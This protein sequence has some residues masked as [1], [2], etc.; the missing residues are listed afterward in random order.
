MIISSNNLISKT[1]YVLDT[2]KTPDDSLTAIEKSIKRN[3][4]KKEKTL[5]K[6]EKAYDS[7]IENAE[8]IPGL[9]NFY[10]VKE[11]LE[12][13]VYL[14]LKPDQLEKEY[15]YSMTRVAGDNISKSFS[16]DSGAMIGNFLMV[17]RK[18]NDKV[19]I[20]KPVIDYRAEQGD[21]I[22]RSLKRAISESL[23]ESLKIEGVNKE[24]GNILVDATKFFMK[25][26]N[27]SGGDSLKKAL[28]LGGG[29][30]AISLDISNSYFDKIRSSNDMSCVEVVQHF[31]GGKGDSFHRVNCSLTPRPNTGYMP[32]YNNQRL[33]YFTTEYENMS[34]QTSR[35]PQK[36][37][38]NRFQ[39]EKADPNLPLS[40]PKQPITFWLDN[41][42]PAKYKDA[43]RK[44]LLVWNKVFE[45]VGIKN[46]IVVNDVPENEEGEMADANRNMVYSIVNTNLGAYAVGPSFADPITGQ[47]YSAKIRVNIPEFVR[48]YDS[49]AEKKMKPIS[50]KAL[51]AFGNEIEKELSEILPTLQLSGKIDENTTNAIT[52]YVQNKM[53][54]QKLKFSS[55][56]DNKQDYAEVFKEELFSA[57]SYLQSVGALNEEEKDKMIQ[58]AIKAVVAHEVGHTLGLRHNFKGSLYRAEDGRF[59][60]IMDYLPIEIKKDT[61]GKVSY[62]IQTEPGPSEYAAIQYG[63]SQIP[64][65]KT[66]E[67]E[68]PYLDAIAK[69]AP[70]FGSDEEAMF[71]YKTVRHDLGEPLQFCK[72]EVALAKELYS[73]I[74]KFEVPGGNFS[75]LRTQF[76]TVMRLYDK[77]SAIAGNYIGGFSYNRGKIG[78]I[79]GGKNPIEPAPKKEQMA[80]LKFLKETFLKEDS[81]KFSPE[82]LK[83]LGPKENFGYA[84]LQSMSYPIH[85][86]VSN[87]QNGCLDA[88]FRPA[89]LRGIVENQLKD[90]NQLKMPELFQ[91]VKNSVWSELKDG[92]NINSLRRNL[93]RNYVAKL[94]S[95]MA[96]P[97]GLMGLVMMMMTGPTPDDAK[98]QARMDLADLEKQIKCTLDNP[99]ITLDSETKAHLNDIM[100]QIK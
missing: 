42:I 4:E 14:E 32:R 7:K 59:G 45:G 31:S 34:E 20:I 51:G 71:D 70:L 82:L 54:E 74:E 13:K 88:I 15:L 19:Q 97:Q 10:R 12:E 41:A 11:E 93:Q 30:N 26:P 5:S 76:T 98:A 37:F 96:G 21:P 64:G 79:I 18:I 36:I 50:E 94:Q 43:V 85:D 56:S 53:E 6:M 49:I 86:V 52:E 25:D 8:K 44:G 23:Y 72:N 83:K 29:A 60:A 38:I 27:K 16:G 22:G 78:E 61:K 68:V 9:F 99:S 91:E 35:D 81:F 75:S 84:D 2:S 66:P 80:A 46:A 89:G 73:K 67:D 39:I 63:Y 87:I 65:V 100:A 55:L 1:P 47:I 62:Y 48:A 57:I 40:P 77:T 28:S 95:L 24:N 17:F 90:S 33:P 69:N 58:A 92:K 3:Q